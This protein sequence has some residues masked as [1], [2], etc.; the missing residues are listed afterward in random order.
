MLRFTPRQVLYILHSRT[1]EDIQDQCS[2]SRRWCS[3]GLCSPSEDFVTESLGCRVWYKNSKHIQELRKCFYYKNYPLSGRMFKTRL[4]N[5]NQLR[6]YF[7][8]GFAD[9]EKRLPVSGITNIT[10]MIWLIF[11]KYRK[12]SKTILSQY[13]KY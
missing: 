4:Q 5:L 12:G 11:K 9:G 1:A 13:L 10:S 3:G 2:E 6:S 7:K 8:F